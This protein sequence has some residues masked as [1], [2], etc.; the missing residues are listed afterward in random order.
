MVGPFAQPMTDPKKVTPWNEQLHPFVPDHQLSLPAQMA[1][2][3]RRAQEARPTAGG[4][5]RGNAAGGEFTLRLV[6]FALVLSAAPLLYPLAAIAAFLTPYGL[7]A[8]AQFASLG[9]YMSTWVT[10]PISLLVL[11][12]AVRL[13]NSTGR[14]MLYRI[15]RHLLRLSLLFA[16]AIYLLVPALPHALAN[17]MHDVVLADPPWRRIAGALAVVLAAHFFLFHLKGLRRWWHE[18]MQSCR[19]RSARL[20][21]PPVS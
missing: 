9:P 1:R 12:A 2:Q 13:E 14:F 20:P 6:G 7:I 21:L 17:G 4:G 5:G 19:L 18:A 16:G 3:Q 11:F 8:L 10:L 15:L